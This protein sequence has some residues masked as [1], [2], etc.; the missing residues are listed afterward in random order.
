MIL[1]IILFIFSIVLFYVVVNVYGTVQ[2]IGLYTKYSDDLLNISLINIIMGLINI[3]FS[4]MSF[5]F[6]ILV[7]NSCERQ[8]SHQENNNV[9]VILNNNAKIQKLPQQ[10][11]ENDV[12]LSKK[13]EFPNNQDNGVPSERV[14][15]LPNPNQ[16]GN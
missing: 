3:F 14:E 5:T 11:R 4:V 8:I 13:T 6:S 10:N 16:N 2:Q 7:K 1:S 12:I 9:N 15:V